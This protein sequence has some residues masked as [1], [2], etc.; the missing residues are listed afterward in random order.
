MKEIK[1]ISNTQEMAT[2][3]KGSVE[4]LESLEQI[5]IWVTLAIIEQNGK[6][7]IGKRPADKPY[8]GKWEFP[9]GKIENGEAPEACLQREV[10]EEL[11]TSLKTINPYLEWDYGFPD[12]NVYHL[13]AFRGVIS[14]DF[15]EKYA[16]DELRWVSADE[17][18]GYDLLESDQI[19]VESLKRAK[20]P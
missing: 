11:G 2:E 17:L 15:L 3:P 9:G 8:G 10:K 18:D 5:T 4:F 1:K 12:G 16:H 7:L 19:L 13:I 6:F 14:G 20:T